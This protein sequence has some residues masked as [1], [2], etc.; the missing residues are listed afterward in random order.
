MRILNRLSVLSVALVGVL[1]VFGAQG[2]VAAQ[3]L[4]RVGAAEPS[5]T[6]QSASAHYRYRGKNYAYRYE[7]KYYNHRSQQNGHWQY[8]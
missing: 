2:A 3:G 1:Y 7:G 4:T 6:V 8:H 5:P